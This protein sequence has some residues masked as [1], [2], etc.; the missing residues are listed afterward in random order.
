MSTWHRLVRHSV[1]NVTPE[2]IDRCWP[3]MVGIGNGWPS[4]TGVDP[5][6]DVYLSLSLT[7][8]TIYVHSPDGDTAVPRQSLRSPTRSYCY[9]Y[10]ASEIASE[11][12]PFGRL[13]LWQHCHCY[14]MDKC[15]SCHYRTFT[16]DQQWFWH[17]ADKSLRWQHSATSWFATPTPRPINQFHS[18]LRQL[19]SQNCQCDFCLLHL[20]Q[21]VIIVCSTVPDS[22][23]V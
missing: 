8:Y 12:F 13:L 9:I 4:R 1:G 20:S 17:H 23:S 10:L 11:I 3:N 19:K 6:R 18:D 21:V 15:Y 16:R 22:R 5:G 7:F 2:R 14:S